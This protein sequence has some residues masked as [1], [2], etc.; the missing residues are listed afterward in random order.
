MVDFEYC[1][2]T[3]LFFGKCVIKKMEDGYELYG[4]CC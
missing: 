3:K 4:L 2:P 1:A